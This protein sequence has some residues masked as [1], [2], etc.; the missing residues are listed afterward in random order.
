MTEAGRLA[1]PRISNARGA[2]GPTATA[3]QSHL[4]DGL[5]RSRAIA[6][7]SGTDPIE[8]MTNSQKP[9]AISGVTRHDSMTAISAP[10]L[11]KM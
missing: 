2:T 3:I 1:S 9:M 5:L 6:P 10:A 11:R 7:A 4:L 8:M